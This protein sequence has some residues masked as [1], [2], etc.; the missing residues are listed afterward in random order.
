MLDQ[1]NKMVSYFHSLPE[2]MKGMSSFLIYLFMFILQLLIS[3]L[4]LHFFS[5]MVIM[6]AQQETVTETQSSSARN[7]QM[8]KDDIVRLIHLFKE[9][10]VLRH[11]MNLHG[12]IK[13]ADLDARKAPPAY[14][15]SAN[16]LSYLVEMFINNEEFIPQNLMVE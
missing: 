4:V 12:I 1:R 15:K 5:E 11:W 8:S 9:P 13:R 7:T 2:E 3:F 6:E 14:A 16:P 10:S